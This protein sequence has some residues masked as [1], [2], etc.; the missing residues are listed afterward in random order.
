MAVLNAL[1]LERA[2]RLKS[3][4]NIGACRI[5]EM[6]M[7]EKVNWRKNNEFFVFSSLSFF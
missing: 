6:P 5:E 2:R 7:G 1:S 3:K 4:T